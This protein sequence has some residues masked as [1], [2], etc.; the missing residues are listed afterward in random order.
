MKTIEKRTKLRSGDV[1]L[2]LRDERINLGDH[3][4]Y[5]WETENQFEEAVGFLLVGIRNG[6][7]VVVFGHDDANNKVVD[8]LR[9]RGIDTEHLLTAGTAH[10]DYRWTNRRENAGQHRRDV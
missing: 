5:F 6:D 4:A 8:L 3:I 1:Q 9:K 2:G 10:G 7:H